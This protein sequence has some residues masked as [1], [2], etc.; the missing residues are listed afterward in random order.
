MVEESVAVCTLV[1]DGA[2]TVEAVGGTC[3]AGVRVEGV[4]CLVDFEK[5]AVARGTADF[6]VDEVVLTLGTVGRTLPA[7]ANTVA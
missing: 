5:A 3:L 6:V 1:A 7:I 2:V 4:C